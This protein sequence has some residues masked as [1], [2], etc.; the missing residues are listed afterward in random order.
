MLKCEDIIF[1]AIYKRVYTALGTPLSEYTNAKKVREECTEPIER[2]SLRF[3]VM[4]KS[5]IK[6]S[7]KKASNGHN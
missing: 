5:A 6:N 4:I 7:I 2:L 3:V 1:R